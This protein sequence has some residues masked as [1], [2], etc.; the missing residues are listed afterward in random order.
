M[1]IRQAIPRIYNPVIQCDILFKQNVTIAVKHGRKKEEW[2]FF[3]AVLMNDL[4][5]KKECNDGIDFVA[6]E[7]DEQQLVLDY[8]DVELFEKW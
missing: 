1:L 4:L 5:I 8:G 2:G 3:L 6:L 7:Q